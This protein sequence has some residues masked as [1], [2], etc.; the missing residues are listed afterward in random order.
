MRSY[1]DYSF[2]ARPHSYSLADL[3]HLEVVRRGEEADRISTLSGTERITAQAIE[4]NR[5]AEWNREFKNLQDH[6]QSQRRQ[7]HDAII[8]SNTL[9]SSLMHP[10]AYLQVSKSSCKTKRYFP[11]LA[12]WLKRRSQKASTN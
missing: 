5:L 10:I 12:T 2:L 11:T 3:Q 1:S 4:D 7:Q 6:A 9:P 8:D